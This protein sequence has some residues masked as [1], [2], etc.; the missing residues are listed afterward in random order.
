MI[1]V[2]PASV[3]S[4]N[5]IWPWFIELIFS[6]PCVR[7]RLNAHERLREISNY[8]QSNTLVIRKCICP[9]DEPQ[10]QGVYQSWFHRIVLRLCATHSF[11][12]RGSVVCKTPHFCWNFPITLRDLG[13]IR[14]QL[15][16][17]NVPYLIRF[18]LRLAGYFCGLCVENE[19]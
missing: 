3:I 5:R 6:T 4:A 13:D 9:P 8:N 14:A 1:T 15:S 11:N 18:S 12:E 16:L 2:M 17:H 7:Y 19:G 10:L